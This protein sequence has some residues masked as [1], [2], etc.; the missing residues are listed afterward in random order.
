VASGWK[1]PLV[2]Y[3]RKLH[4]NVGFADV[5]LIENFIKICRFI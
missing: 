3:C 2:E 5:D 1:I 4:E